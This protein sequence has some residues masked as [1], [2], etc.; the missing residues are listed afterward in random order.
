VLLVPPPTRPFGAGLATVLLA[1]FPAAQASALP[2]LAQ[3]RHLR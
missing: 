3:R 2:G 1:V